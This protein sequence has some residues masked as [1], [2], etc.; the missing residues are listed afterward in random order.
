MCLPLLA[1]DSPTGESVADS[2]NAPVHLTPTP[3]LQNW[4]R[5]HTYYNKVVLQPHTSKQTNLQSLYHSSPSPDGLPLAE[6]HP[7]MRGALSSMTILSSTPATIFI[8]HSYVK[9]EVDRYNSDGICFLWL[10]PDS[11]VRSNGFILASRDGIALRQHSRFGTVQGY[12]RTRVTS[13]ALV[14]HAVRVWDLEAD[15]GSVRFAHSSSS[16]SFT[17]HSPLMPHSHAQHAGSSISLSK[18][19]LAHG[20]T[21]QEPVRPLTITAGI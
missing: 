5:S 1:S 15:T 14:R 12:N 11:T 10:R 4:P 19:T 7:S 21:D 18:P 9:S 20:V 17:P 13:A 8:A 3:P 6:V 2:A 16:S